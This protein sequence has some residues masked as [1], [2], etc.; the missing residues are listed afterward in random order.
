MSIFTLIG[1]TLSNSVALLGQIAK[2]YKYAKRH[3]FVTC[4]Y[5]DSGEIYE[6]QGTVN[7]QNNSVS[8]KQIQQEFRITRSYRRFPQGDTVYICTK[9]CPETIDLSTNNIILDDVRKGSILSSLA[10]DIFRTS[11]FKYMTAQNKRETILLII[12][13]SL[14]SIVIGIV[15]GS[16]LSS[17][18]VPT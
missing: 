4:L 9:E 15:I 14:V 13:F 7:P 3:R 11:I 16:A 12:V 2:D 18:N 8:P 17:G 5:E 10:Y 1:N 6:F